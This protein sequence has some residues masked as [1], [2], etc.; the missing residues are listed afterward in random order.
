MP[1][2]THGSRSFDLGFGWQINLVRPAGELRAGR[3]GVVFD[4]VA[5]GDVQS[6]RV[7]L[8]PDHIRLCSDAGDCGGH[9]EDCHVD[10]AGAG[11]RRL[12]VR[13]L[14]M[15]DADQVHA[16]IGHIDRIMAMGV[17]FGARRLLHALLQRD[18]DHIVTV[19]GLI[20]GAV[21]DGAGDRGGERGRNCGWNEEK[22]EGERNLQQASHVESCLGYCQ[23]RNCG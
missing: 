22:G 23:L 14:L 17:G 1:P 11:R 20:G 16:L 6:L 21:G 12:E 18:E 4:E 13:G 3:R 2:G 8:D 7:C 5:L 19:G 15:V 9:V 10:S